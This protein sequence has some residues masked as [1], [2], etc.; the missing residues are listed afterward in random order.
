[1]EQTIRDNLNNPEA[2]E[3]LFRS[4]AAQ[5]RE[6]FDTI[7]HEI[8]HHTTARVW[9]A[10]LHYSRREEHSRKESRRMILM[11]LLPAIALAGLIARLP[12]NLSISPDFFYSR[13]IGFVVLPFLGILLAWRHKA[14][15]RISF[16][17]GV[18]M[19]LS[20]VYINLLPDRDSSDTLVLACIHLPLLMWGVV[21]MLGLGSDLKATQPRMAYLRFNG[22]LVV[23]S[24]L[25]ALATAL[26]MALTFGL[27]GLINVDIEY[28]VEHYL[29]YWGAPALPLAAAFL[30]TNNPTLVNKI[31]PVIARIFTP[32]VLLML[33]FFLVAVTYSGK[34]PYTDREFLLLFNIILIGVM[35]LICFA[36]TGKAGGQRND[37]GI[38]LLFALSLVALMVNGV[39]LSA[40]VY[41]LSSWGVTPNRL[42]VLGGNLLMLIH[43]A[44][45][46]VQ[47]FKTARL[48]TASDSIEKSIAGFLP[49]YLIWAVVVAFLFPIVFGFA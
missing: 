41:R 31:S 5:F 1:M 13:N 12:L 47:L 17:A 15:F 20:V 46:S 29:S 14:S 22:D 25:L 35:A 9:H 32:L 11:W 10:R 18:G 23:M 27:F 39:A 16:A 4:D 44:L 45:V 48:K 34:S 26:L 19:L 37:Y 33:V 28:F 2:L 43:L 24:A 38:W 49:W 36:I 42:A 21:G 30:V 8:A 3:Q 7:Y 6:S 40:I